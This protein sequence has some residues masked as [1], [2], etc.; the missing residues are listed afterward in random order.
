MHRLEGREACQMKRCLF[1]YEGS[2]HCCPNGP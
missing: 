2:L 1:L